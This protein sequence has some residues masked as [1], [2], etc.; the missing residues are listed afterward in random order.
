VA[1]QEALSSRR[2][3]AAAVTE[4]VAVAAAA[5][6]RLRLDVVLAGD[7]AVAR[8]RQQDRFC[9]RTAVSRRR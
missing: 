9:P 8:P 5:M 7:A 6:V 2:R 3:V 1:L 4:R